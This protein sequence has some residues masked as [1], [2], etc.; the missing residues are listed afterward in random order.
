MIESSFGFVRSFGRFAS[1]LSGDSDH[2]SDPFGDTSF[3]RDDEVLDISS[4]D[5]VTISAQKSAKAKNR[6]RE[7]LTFHR[8]ILS[9]SATI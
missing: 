9:T 5:D 3:F 1:I 2:S 4:F 7:R 8:R 6:K